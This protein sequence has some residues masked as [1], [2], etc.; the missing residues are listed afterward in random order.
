M[1]KFFSYKLRRLA[2]KVLA[3]VDAV[4]ST[5]IRL[6]DVFLTLSGHCRGYSRLFWASQDYICE[7][8]YLYLTSMDAYTWMTVF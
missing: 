2:S 6:I 8:R 4:A 1:F 5:T 7:Y 3:R